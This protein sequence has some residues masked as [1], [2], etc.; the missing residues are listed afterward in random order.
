MISESHSLKYGAALGTVSLLVMALATTLP[1]AY[2][3]IVLPTLNAIS[4][5]A[6]SAAGGN[7]VTLTGSNFPGRVAVVFGDS[8]AY[9][10]S[11]YDGPFASC[12]TSTTC[13][14]TSSS[15]TGVVQIWILLV[16]GDMRGTIVPTGIYFTYVPVPAVTS[17]SPQNGATTGGATV[18]ISGS[19]LNGATDVKF[20]TA[21]ASQFSVLSNSF[22]SAT[23]PP[24]TGTVDVTVTTTGGTTST[25]DATE[26]RYIDV[27]SGPVKV[28][29][30]DPASGPANGGTSVAITGLGFAKD[31]TVKFGSAPAS[32][33]SCSST[34]T[35]TAVS[36]PGSGT[37]DITVSTAAGTSTTSAISQFTYHPVPSVT[38]IDTEQGPL[39]GGTPIMITGSGFVAPL[40]V[41]FGSVPATDITITSDTRLTV[42]SPPSS[43]GTVDITVTTAGGTS[44]SDQF[45]YRAAPGVAS[46]TPSRGSIAGGNTITITGTGFTGATAVTFT[47]IHVFWW[48]YGPTPAA[49]FTVNS[50]TKITAVTPPGTYTVDVTVTTPGGTSG[51]NSSDQ[52]MYGPAVLNFNSFGTSGMGGEP[53]T[54]LGQGFTGATNVTFAGNAAPSFSVDSDGQITAIPPPG[55][56]FVHVQVTTP[57]GTS[58]IDPF[59]DNVYEPYASIV[60]GF[61]CDQIGYSMDISGFSPG[62]GPESGGTVLN[63]TGGGFPQGTTVI[64]GDSAVYSGDSGVAA[65]CP[66]IFSCTV[67]TPPGT[68][69][70][71]LWMDDRGTV[72]PSGKYFTYTATE[73]PKLKSVAPSRGGGGLAELATPNA[74]ITG[75]ATGASTTADGTVYISVGADPIIHST[76]IGMG[77][78][79]LAQYSSA[80]IAPGDSLE[81]ATFFGLHV[82]SDSEFERVSIAL[83]SVEQD[84]G[85]VWWNGTVWAPVNQSY[86]SVD[87][88]VDASFDSESAPAVSQ[89]STIQ[90]AAL[91][92]TTAPE[93]TGFIRDIVLFPTAGGAVLEYGEI[94]ASDTDP[95]L[96]IAYSIQPGARLAAGTSALVTIT[97]TDSA[98]NSATAL[99]NV[100]VLTPSESIEELQKLVADAGLPSAVESQLTSKLDDAK[101]YLDSGDHGNAKTQLNIFASL[102]ETQGGK[103]MTQEQADLLIAGA[104]SVIRSI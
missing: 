94:M 33:V 88:C 1:S 31:T 100:H 104:N 21:S 14:V 7:T 62:T 24:G 41:N 48:A 64:F 51:A 86:D 58:P 54:I 15:G 84:I 97:V 70:V 71:Q 5:S 57:L 55:T 20:G 95:N 23:A 98:G 34:T 79:T 67:T 53:F 56:G 78:I 3:D 30:I 29:A 9:S 91:A 36:P 90:F 85:I 27:G 93:I 11:G 37:V 22:I 74:N 28:A 10:G 72:Y 45:T 2:A 75:H 83:C 59:C 60:I 68:G 25:G 99:V 65:Y 26:F 40:A 61:A 76:A 73:A 6:G 19:D 50:D 49:S 12:A 42:N 82:T 8:A 44:G 43:P 77:S 89:I 87:R 32:M 101:Q 92:D 47:P 66:T 35:C 80:P 81:N 38:G 13:T 18:T 96:T 46:V 63:I 39:E 4:P 16:D 17:I 102:V 103:S 52:Y 69:S